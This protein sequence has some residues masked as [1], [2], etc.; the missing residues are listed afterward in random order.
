[1]ISMLLFRM[2]PYTL[3]VTTTAYFIYANREQGEMLAKK[4]QALR[5]EQADAGAGAGGRASLFSLFDWQSR[6]SA[7]SPYGDE[8][9]KCTVYY[10]RAVCV[11][12]LY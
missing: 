1:M 4:R 9:S 7:W 11:E 6:S 5:R 2:L 10:M 8:H 3:A 12:E